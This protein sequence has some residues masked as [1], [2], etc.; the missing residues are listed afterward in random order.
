MA[1]KWN[2]GD[3]VPPGKR[4]GAQRR[5]VESERQSERPAERREPAREQ[6]SMGDVRR[7]PSSARE[8]VPLREREVETVEEE[9]EYQPPEDRGEQISIKD[10]RRT[11][12]KAWLITTLVLCVAV[13]GGLFATIVLGGAEVTVYPKHRE[14]A[15]SA[16]FTGHL[17]PGANDLG[18]ELLSLAEEGEKRVTATG[19]EK[20]TTKSTGRIIVYNSFSTTPQRLI[21]NTR[22]EST[23]GF[24]FRISESIVV[25]G[26]KKK[27]DGS[28]EPGSISATVFADGTGDTY[29]LAPTRFTVPGLKGSEQFD[30]VYAESKEKFGGGFDGM[31]YIINEEELATAKQSLHQELRDVLLKKVET[32]KPNGYIFYE[33]SITFAYNT[34][35]ATDAGPQTVVIK[36]QARLLAPLFKMET[37]ASRIAK[38]TVPG[39]TSDPIRIV[40]PNTLTFSYTSSSTDD[41]STKETLDFTLNGKATL[42]WVFDSEALRS[43]LKG[44]GKTAL[45]TVISDYPGIDKAEVKIK[46]FW[47]TS[48]PTDISEIS[49]VE[50][51]KPE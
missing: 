48:F 25:P 31:K 39:Y 5:T 28:I 24:I 50:V 44:I 16:T 6:R 29:N 7:T 46:P 22:F 3:I 41:I 35:P 26:Y 19:Q 33:P 34:L 36:E 21:K 42:V 9:S 2:L 49:I 37:F 4:E 45:P 23:D 17:K 12:A 30:K 18:Y 32:T 11:R 27:A 10:L 43:G 47:K 13:G 20:V 1:Q 40:D 14:V 38:Q 8:Q 51:S 15:V